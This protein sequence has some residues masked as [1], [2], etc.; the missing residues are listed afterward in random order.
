M[1]FRQVPCKLG[2][3]KQMVRSKE[4]PMYREIEI[5]IRESA[6]PAEDETSY[7]LRSPANRDRLLRAIAQAERGEDLVTLDLGDLQ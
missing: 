4:M 6:E 7:L 2:K 1:T 5:A 3:A